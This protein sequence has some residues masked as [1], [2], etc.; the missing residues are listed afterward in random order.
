GRAV[1]I[2]SGAMAGGIA[3]GSEL[4]GL[5]QEHIMWGSVLQKKVPAKVH[6]QVQVPVQVPEFKYPEP[7]PLH[8]HIVPQ[9]IGSLHPVKKRLNENAPHRHHL[10]NRQINAA[11]QLKRRG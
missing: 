3:L 7:R 11:R 9:Y 1:G 10:R 8:I 2:W 5:K 4:S 6:Q